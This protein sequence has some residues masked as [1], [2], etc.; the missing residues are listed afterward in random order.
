M[1]LHLQ[2]NWEF[3][4]MTA[5]CAACVVFCIRFGVVRDAN[6]WKCCQRL[7]AMHNVRIVAAGRVVVAKKRAAHLD[8]S[9]FA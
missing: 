5:V 9:R 3:G 6:S 2:K 1:A 4:C 8:P 7:A